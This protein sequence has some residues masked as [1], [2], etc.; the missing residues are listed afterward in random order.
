MKP[1]RSRAPNLRLV[2]VVS[3]GNNGCNGGIFRLAGNIGY[4]RSPGHHVDGGSLSEI[5]VGRSATK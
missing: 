3:I 4:H 2:F 5:F 1:L